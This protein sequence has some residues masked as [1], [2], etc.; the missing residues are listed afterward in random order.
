[1]M[2]G[3]FVVCPSLRSL[4]SLGSLRSA[5]SERLRAHLWM[6]AV[7][8]L[9]AVVFHLPA[10]RVPFVWDDIDTIVQNPQMQGSEGLFRYFQVDYWRHSHAVLMSPYRPVRE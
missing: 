9:V 10:F 1:M 7:I 6:S 2:Q 8:V 3:P 5:M 4:G